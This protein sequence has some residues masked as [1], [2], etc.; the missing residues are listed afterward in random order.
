MEVNKMAKKSF[1][2]F[3]DRH[4]TEAMTL[5]Q[6]QIEKSL[7]TVVLL[8]EAIDFVAKGDIRNAR[9][10]IEKLFKEEE[11]VDELR[12]SVFRKM[13]NVAISIEFREDFM[14]LVKR[15][16]VMADQIKDA[17]RCVALLM[18]RKVPNE[19]WITYVT[20]IDV[21]VQSSKSLRDSIEQLGSNVD[22]AV[23]KARETEQY[24]SQIDK[25]HF[26][27]RKSFVRYVDQVDTSTLILLN[28]L[29]GFIEEASDVC[30]DTADYISILAGER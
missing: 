15:L 27:I 10:D 25:Q 19:I 13:T 21:M 5:A 3:D 4:R 2:W 12:R 14:H 24:E 23:Q 1:A 26:E 7:G 22:K 6:K 11:M 9:N 28:E 8:K 17:A 29:V 18:E 30:A 20:M 16:D